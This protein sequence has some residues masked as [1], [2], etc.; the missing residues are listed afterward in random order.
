MQGCPELALLVTSR[1]ALRLRAE[2]RFPVP[3]LL[4][5]ADRPA[6][7]AGP[8]LAALAAR[9]RCACSW[10]GRRRSHPSF[11]LDAGTALGSRRSAAGWTACRWPSSWR[12]RGWPCCHP[13]PCCGA[14]GSPATDAPGFDPDRARM[15]AL[16]TAGPADLPER[17]RT[18]R[19]HPGL[20]PRPARA[21]R[22]GLVP[23]PGGLRRRLDPGSG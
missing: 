4:A 9:R 19:A 22:A 20:E 23:A 11:V 8:A 6:S 5:P 10:N 16:L 13:R 1:A 17:Q 14:C 7:D 15:L 3:P 12:R 18:L 2:R 21:G